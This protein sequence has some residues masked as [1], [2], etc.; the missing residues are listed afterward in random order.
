MI[1]LEPS[2][3]GHDLLIKA[4]LNYHQPRFISKSQSAIIK[5]MIEW[6]IEPCLKFVHN[7][8][9]RIM[10]LSSLHMIMSFLNLFNCML[11]DIK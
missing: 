4:W 6:F 5:M 8:C 3:L 2:S 1:Y 9:D 7:N 11:Q 10:K